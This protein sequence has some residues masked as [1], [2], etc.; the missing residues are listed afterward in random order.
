MRVRARTAVKDDK[1]GRGTVICVGG[2]IRQDSSGYRQ[3]GGEE[4]KMTK[5]ENVKEGL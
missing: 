5:I 3:E 2:G 4:G 1:E